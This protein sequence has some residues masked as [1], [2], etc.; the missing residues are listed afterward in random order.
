[1]SGQV[2]R[3]YRQ[4]TT[5]TAWQN[6]SVIHFDPINLAQDTVGSPTEVGK[7]GERGDDWMILIP[8][9]NESGLITYTGR[10]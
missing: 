5:K 7:R 2:T 4:V 10:S 6:P 8:D 1:M 3:V 9:S